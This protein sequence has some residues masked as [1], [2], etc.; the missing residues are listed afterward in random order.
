MAWADGKLQGTEER[1]AL[2]LPNPPGRSR[3]TL[4]LTVR[5]SLEWPPSVG[6][7]RAHVGR[8]IRCHQHPPVTS[9]C[10]IDR[11]AFSPGGVGRLK[12]LLPSC[13]ESSYASPASAATMAP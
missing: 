13:L 6:W 11:P 7:P 9:A 1:S 12:A 8:Q 4:N 10:D 5:M 2:K 3:W